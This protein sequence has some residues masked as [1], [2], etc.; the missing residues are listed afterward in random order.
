M[1]RILVVDDSATQRDMVQIL[2]EEAG[3]TVLQADDGKPALEIIHQQQPHLVITDLQMKEVDGLE[4]VRTVRENWPQI[5]VVLMTQYGSETI[6]AEALRLGASN[7]IPKK[8][9]QEQLGRIVSELLEVVESRTKRDEMTAA[10]RSVQRAEMEFVIGNDPRQAS[11]LVAFLEDQL[12]QLDC[13]DQAS[14][15]RIVLALKE[16]LVNAIDHGNLEL[17]SKLRELENNE[18]HRLAEQRRIQPPYC[19]RKVTVV[20]RLEP[21]AVSYTISDE[22]PG[23]D[24]SQIPDPRDPENLVKASGRGLMLIQTFM[25]DVY[26]SERGN[27]ITM[28]KQREHKPT[29]QLAP[30]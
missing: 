16:A 1:A 14:V 18:Y 9:L 28:V 21:D 10:L 7:F 3:H 19:D 12:H 24:P 13:F 8:V 15:F 30:C 23:F 26:F 11:R 6:A 17:D 5:P 25:D 20:Y 2:L 22:G 29:A 27:T 4:V